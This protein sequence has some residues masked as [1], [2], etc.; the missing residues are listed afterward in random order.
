VPL[1]SQNHLTLADEPAWEKLIANVRHFMATGQPLPELPGRTEMPEADAGQ[2]TPREVEVLRLMAEG[3]S[4]QEIASELV[5]SINTVTN[6]VKNILGKTE[7]ANRTEAAAFA[8][9]HGLTTTRN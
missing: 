9:R 6:H 1:E 8:H 3:R 5:I 7:T 2:L 4:N